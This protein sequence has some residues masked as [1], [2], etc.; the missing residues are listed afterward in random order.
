MENLHT[1]YIPW[2]AGA[3]ELSPLDMEKT[4]LNWQWELLLHIFSTAN[5]HSGDSDLKQLKTLLQRKLATGTALQLGQQPST[6]LQETPF[7]LG[8]LP[9]IR[10]PINVSLSMRVC[11]T[12]CWG[13]WALGADC[14][15]ALELHFAEE[16]IWWALISLIL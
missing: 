16:L 13:T 8:S 11:A 3:A 7:P 1:P 5:P 14:S 6:P 12:L 15:A 10:V 2:G 9:C 4:L